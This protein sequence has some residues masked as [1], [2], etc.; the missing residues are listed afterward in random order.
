MKWISLRIND[1]HHVF[2]VSYSHH[3]LR[4]ERNCSPFQLWNMVLWRDVMMTMSH[5]KFFS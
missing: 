5:G 2:Q 3:R 4:M 1:T